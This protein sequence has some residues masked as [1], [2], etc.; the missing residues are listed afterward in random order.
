MHTYPYTSLL[1]SHVPLPIGVVL[2]TPKWATKKSKLLFMI[3]TN[4]SLVLVNGELGN[5]NISVVSVECAI[6][7]TTQNILQ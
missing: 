3:L 1:K 4:N 7:E 5:N 2:K 6:C